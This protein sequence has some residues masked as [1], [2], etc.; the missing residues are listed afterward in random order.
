MQ[1]RGLY[2]Q[3][4]GTAMGG[5]SGNDEDGGFT[6]P[7]SAHVHTHANV[8]EY[9][10]D[11]H[12]I[13]VKDTDVYP[14]PPAPMPYGVAMAP[15]MGPF[16]ATKRSWPHGGTVIGGPSGDDEG[17]TF[18]M[19]ITGNFHTDVNEFNKDDHS[20]KLKDEHVY[21]PPSFHP[22]GVAHGFRESP[23]SAPSDDYHIPA[24]AFAK[25]WGPEVGGTVMGGPG[26]GSGPDGFPGPIEAGGTA[27]GGPSGPDDG[28]DFSAG[29]TGNFHSNVN[30][31]SHD[32]HSVDL[33][34]TDVYPPPPPMEFGPPGFGTPFKRG[35]E[36]EEGAT[37]MG[38]P[39]GDDGGQ[40]FNMPITV[41]THTGVNE[42]WEDD[43]SIDV[44][45]KDV[46]PPVVPF[47]GPG[48]Y[49]PEGGVTPFRRAYSP[50]SPDRMEGG[51]TAM[52]GPSGEDDGINFGTPT[53]I[54]VDS[55]VNEHHEDNHAIKAESTD[56]HLPHMP[57][58]PYH[59]VPA[60][61]QPIVVHEHPVPAPPSP[62]VVEHEEAPACAPQVHE[63]VRTVTKTQTQV[64]HPTET[65]TEAA[66]THVVQST[67]HDTVTVTHTPAVHVVPSTKTVHD[68]ETVTQTPV[69]H[70][71]QV[72]KTVY[73]TPKEHVVQVTDTVYETPTQHVVQTSAIPMSAIP[74][75]TPMSKVYYSSAHGSQFASIPAAP[76]SYVPHQSYEYMSQRPM[77]SGTA[78]SMIPIRVPVAS[79]ASRHMSMASPSMMPSGADPMHSSMASAWAS[80]SPSHGTMFTGDAARLSG[81]IVSVAAAVFGVLAFVL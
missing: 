81:G 68:T 26:G 12:S 6:S 50:G 79:S 80:A 15:G 22:P 11:D 30:E 51:G 72:T 31:Y 60:P 44:K 10:K 48:P 17:Q 7:Y 45:H 40:S 69:E 78:Y 37:V 33:K 19:P 3:P 59:E 65:V 36:P 38:G 27:M 41:D 13:E 57:W 70:V 64:V 73:E 21:S 53:N 14:P 2:P 74:M 77:T 18:D 62:P 8:N 34:H 76:S 49:M 9:S 54:G 24:E 25:R 29:V 52:G 47:G 1:S 35:W 75:E 23:N 5:P 39:S 58:M 67:V 28:V 56:V 61:P 16:E 20:I 43:H 66:A 71:A 42:H 4:G 55:N 32:D 46:Y 63:V